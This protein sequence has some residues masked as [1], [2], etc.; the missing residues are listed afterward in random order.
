M[1]CQ[2]IHAI[3]Q[4]AIYFQSQEVPAHADSLIGNTHIVFEAKANVNIVFILKV[5]GLLSADHDS[6]SYLLDTHNS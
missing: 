6:N 1:V 4:S 3:T 5:L 2:H